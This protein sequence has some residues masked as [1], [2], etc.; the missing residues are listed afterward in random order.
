MSN[1]EYYDIL[2]AQLKRIEKSEYEGYDPFDGLNSELLPKFLFRSRIFRLAF[3]Q[4]NKLSPINFRPLFLIPKGI[5]PKALGLLL[6]TYANLG[7]RTQAKI[8]FD[9]L[10]QFPQSP[11]F[12][13]WGYNFDWQNRVFF[14]P[15]GTPTI[16]NTAF[17]GHGLIDCYEKFGDKFYL[18]AALK[19]VTFFTELLNKSP[20]EV[21]VCFSYTPLD[22]TR[23]HNANLLAAGFLSRLNVYMD[24]AE[25]HLLIGDSVAYSLS[26]QAKDGSWIYGD[27]NSQKFIDSFHTG[28]NLESLEW[29]EKYSPS[30]SLRVSCRNSITL[31]LRYYTQRFFGENGEPYYFS[32]R[33]HLFDIHS[34]AQAIRYLSKSN[35]FTD[36]RLV[37]RILAWT[38]ENMY[39][40]EFFIYRIRNGFKYNI[41]YQRWSSCWMVYALSTYIKS[42]SND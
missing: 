32:N 25:I 15:K 42:L 39:N 24:L 9:I 28:F 31:G 10:I 19:T 8:V 3:L 40:K 30:D 21:G 16:V 27:G 41:E 17:I 38:V 13:A 26:Q 35:Y 23:V 29:V 34:P 14:I 2:N 1:S 12:N 22:S 4:F 37:E 6:S 5:N 36:Q 7:N 11:D 33:S 18:D 20:S